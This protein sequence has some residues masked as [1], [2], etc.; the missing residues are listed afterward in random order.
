MHRA[1]VPLRRIHLNQYDIRKL[2]RREKRAAPQTTLMKTMKINAG[3]TFV[4]VSLADSRRA[5]DQG[6][7]TGEGD[8][9]TNCQI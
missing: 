8:G 7:R 5:H 9:L 3:A 1:M 2:I 6:S 4:E